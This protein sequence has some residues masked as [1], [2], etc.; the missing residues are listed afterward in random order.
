MARAR[1]ARTAPP[2]RSIP[3]APSAAPAGSTNVLSLQPTPTKK[4]RAE[5]QTLVDDIKQSL[6]LLRRHL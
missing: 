1:A 2:S 3:T 6:G 4:M 5:T